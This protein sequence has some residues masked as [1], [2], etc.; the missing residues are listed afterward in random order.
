MWRDVQQHIN[1]C[2]MLI[3][4]LLSKMYA[5]L[6]HLE[7][8]QVPF[9]GCMMDCTRPLPATSKGHRHAL[10]LLCLLTSYLI[11]VPL[12][13]KTADE[14]W[15]AYMKE[16]LPKTLCPRFI[17]QDNGTEFKSEQLMSVFYSLGIKLIFTAIHTT[18]R[19]IVG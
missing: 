15:M 2:R 8:P 18:L 17:L 9:A 4:F 14:V 7:L 6:L 5:H 13:T 12:K 1:T 16:R 3:Q 11:T 10:T 19:V